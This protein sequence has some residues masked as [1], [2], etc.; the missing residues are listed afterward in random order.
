MDVLKEIPFVL[1]DV[2][3]PHGDFMAYLETAGAREWTP[4]PLPCD[5]SRGEPKSC[6]MNAS[7]AML[8]DDSLDYCEGVAIAANITLPF[9]HAWAVDADGNV[10]DPTWDNPEKCRYYGVRYDR[11]KYTRH[12]FKTQ[13]YG[14]F[15]GSGRIARRILKKGGL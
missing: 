14:V 6:F 3:V 10:V 2:P 15:G 13:F 11:K 9:L 7:L 12:I 8:A 4:A 5:V 1:G